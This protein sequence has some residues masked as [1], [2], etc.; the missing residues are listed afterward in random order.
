MSW[1]GRSVTTSARDRLAQLTGFR[2][3]EFRRLATAGSIESGNWTPIELFDVQI[4][5]WPAHLLQSLLA[6]LGDGRVLIVWRVT[7]NG[8]EEPAYKYFAVSDDGGLTFSK[9]AVFRYSDGK[10]FF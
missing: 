8:K 9:P 6:E 1:V 7:K 2:R 3:R 10:R 4:D 5:D